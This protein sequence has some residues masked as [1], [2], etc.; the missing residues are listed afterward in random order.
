M[1]SREHHD[2]VNSSRLGSEGT[3]KS[4]ERIEGKMVT[5][6]EIVRVEGEVEGYNRVMSVEKL[7]ELKEKS[8]REVYEVVNDVM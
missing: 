4:N 1:Q 5:V 3:V 7:E 8:S 2:P 6:E